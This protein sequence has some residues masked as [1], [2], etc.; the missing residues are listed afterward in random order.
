VFARVTR[1]NAV[2]QFDECE[3]FLS[4]RGQDLERSAIVGIFL[5][6][7]DYYEGILF[8][9]SNRPEVIDE[10]ILSRV[11]LRLTYPG[12]ERRNATGDLARDVLRSG[13]CN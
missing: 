13:G 5:R 10:A 3:I 11:M 6:L 8:L 7:L 12:L 2:L 9:T 4:K 1:W